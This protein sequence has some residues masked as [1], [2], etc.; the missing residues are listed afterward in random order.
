MDNEPPDGANGEKHD[1]GPHVTFSKAVEMLS[2]VH[3]KVN[4][5]NMKTPAAVEIKTEVYD[6]IIE[7]YNGNYQNSAKRVQRNCCSKSSGD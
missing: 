7:V 5:Q 1:G 6:E 3:D 2:D 4:G